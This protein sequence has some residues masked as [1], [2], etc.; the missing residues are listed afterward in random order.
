MVSGVSVVGYKSDKILKR[1]AVVYLIFEKMLE[2]YLL[3]SINFKIWWLKFFV[4]WTFQE[5]WYCPNF[6]SGLFFL[7]ILLDMICI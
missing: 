4:S 1:M 5:K 3:F 2:L 7:Y 6:F